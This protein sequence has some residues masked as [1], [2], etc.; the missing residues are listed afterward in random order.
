VDRFVGYWQKNIL[1][2]QPADA[3]VNNPR[4]LHLRALS[5]YFKDLK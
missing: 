5:N 4:A 1:F 3:Y 2:R